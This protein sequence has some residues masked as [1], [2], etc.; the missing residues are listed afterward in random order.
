MF[1][2]N[3]K[4]INILGRGSCCGVYG[5]QPLAGD[6]ATTLW[7]RLAGGPSNNGCSVRG[8]SAHDWQRR[9][10]LT[11]QFTLT[12]VLGCF[13]ALTLLLYAWLIL[14]F[15]CNMYCNAVWS[16]WFPF[17]ISKLNVKPVLADKIVNVV[18]NPQVSSSAQFEHISLCRL[19]NILPAGQA[20]PAHGVVVNS[21]KSATSY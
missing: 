10:G 17:S 20:D 7:P 16:C 2:E 4:E 6:Y 13:L 8:L 3:R 12:T 14:S 11:G 21:I 5:Q 1:V 9:E 15:P 18:S 19:A